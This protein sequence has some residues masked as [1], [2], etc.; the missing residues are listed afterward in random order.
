MQ[1]EYTQFAHVFSA[2]WHSD[3]LQLLRTG[4]MRDINKI[5]YNLAS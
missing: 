1:P 2:S 3:C 4:L 5:K